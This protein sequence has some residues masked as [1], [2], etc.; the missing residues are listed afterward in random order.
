MTG[1][2]QMAMF[3]PK[4]DW[5]PPAELP[6]I[7]DAEEI[8]IDVETR[9]PNLKNKGPGWPT[10]DGEIVGYAVAVAGWKGYIP[11]GHAGGGNLDFRIVSKW[12][13]KVFES[14]ADKIMHNAQYDLGWIRAHGFTVN[15]RII[16]TMM[17]ASLID[18]NRFSYSLNALSY[19][20]LGKTKSEKTLVEAAKDFGV[21]PKGEMWKLPAMYV[22]PYGETDAE[23]TLELWNHFKTLLNR[24]DLWDIW[25][26]EM[27]L[28]PYLTE[29]TMRGIRVDLDKAE[30]TKQHVMKEEKAVRKHLKSLAGMDVDIWAALPWLRPLTHFH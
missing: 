22:G 16:D 12:L 17:T 9:D 24:E 15:G 8:A 3:P 30:R 11:V 21:D 13:K 20:Y 19:E 25:A 10:K 14:P 6:D 26:L 27:E 1:K 23:L 2:L 7:F 4:T 18:E 28:L 5:V 29:M